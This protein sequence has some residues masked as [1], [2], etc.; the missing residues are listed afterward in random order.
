MEY[1]DRNHNRLALQ[2]YAD[3]L[4]RGVPTTSRNGPV[5]RLPGC[6]TLVAQRPRERVNFCP[7]RDA[8]PFFHLMEAMAMLAA[9]NSVEFL[10]YFAANMRNYS[11]DGER[12]NAFYGTRL[13]EQW[14]DQLET[15]IEELAAKPDSRQAV[16]CLWDPRDLIRSTKDKACNLMLLFELVDGR[17][18]MTSFNRSNDAIWGI[19]S[20]ANVVHMSFFQEYVA[21]ALGKE[22][23]P[24]THVANNLHVYTDNPQ[25]AAVCAA[26]MTDHYG[27]PAVQGCPPLFAEPG[28]RARFDSDLALFITAC[29]Y[30]VRHQDYAPL[31]AFRK[32]CQ[33]L[34]IHSVAMPVFMS[35]HMRKLGD[36]FKADEWASDIQADDWRLAVQ[37]WLNRHAVTPASAR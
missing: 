1:T 19:L 35:W 24:W 3:L 25:W 33:S 20:G 5:L 23:G 4:R 31:L 2:V 14:G 27:T 15:V 11:D 18:C 30:A 17:L 29:V 21:C 34:F 12:Y 7:A 13:R 36:Q 26:R 16:A 22:L 37:G 9:Y 8:N 28:Q 6:T 32:T 10:S